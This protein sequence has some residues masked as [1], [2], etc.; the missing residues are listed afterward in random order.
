M[1]QDQVA[2][3]IAARLRFRLSAPEQ[4]SLA[5]RYTANAEAYESYV[6]GLYTLEG[7]FIS[8]AARAPLESAIER[9]K[10]AVEI[11][12][13]YAL[14]YAHLAI[15][16]SELVNFYRAGPAALDQAKQ[17][18]ARAYALD[19]DLAELHVFRAWMF[20]SLDGHFQIDEA[21]RE[22]RLAER[23]DPSIGH[24]L[25]GNM[26]SHVGLDEEAARE[27]QRAIEIDPTDVT[28]Y[29]RLAESKVWSGQYD[30]AIAAYEK[31]L[32]MKPA[33]HTSY[34]FGA[35]P[36]LYERRYDEA[37]RRLQQAPSV[38][39]GGILTPALQAL[40]LALQGDF[41]RSEAAILLIAQRA[42]GLLAM[43]HVA[44]AAASIHALQG[45]SREAVEWLGKTADNG[46][47]NYPM[48]ARDPNLD[49]IRKDPG[50][51]QFMAGIKTRW[52]RYQQE[53]RNPQ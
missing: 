52:E 31:V 35:L 49:R 10:R 48:F 20:W 40:L 32:S 15:S 30:E 25:L 18:A 16:Y 43:H 2:R 1:V 5:K 38:D 50:F 41:A 12:P 46:M 17:A 3:Q 13:S 47:P 4:T 6:K 36:F 29:D 45:K 11:D 42:E 7:R 26:Y 22:L 9:F 44:Y 28:H 24:S 14:A 39:R 19:P 51:N 37:Q 53:F 21:I 23:L 33:N 34:S 27:L 8:G